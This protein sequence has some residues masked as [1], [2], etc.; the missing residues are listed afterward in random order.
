MQSI[1]EEFSC[2]ITDIVRCSAFPKLAES[3]QPQA[4]ADRGCSLK[5]KR[6]ISSEECRRPKAVSPQVD[7][8]QK[9]VTHGQC[10]ARPTIT[11]PT[12]GHHRPLTGTK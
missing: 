4:V 8:P 7:K 1:T 6:T 3:G 12:A 2:D 9:S 11:F 10:D 5:V